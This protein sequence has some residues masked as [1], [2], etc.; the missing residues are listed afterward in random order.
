MAKRIGFD[1]TADLDQPRENANVV[2]ALSFWN[3]ALGE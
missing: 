3:Q 1:A 2:T